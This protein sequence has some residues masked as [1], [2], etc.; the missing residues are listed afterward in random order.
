[1]SKQ[2]CAQSDI[3]WTEY[4]PGRLVHIR[5]H[6]KLRHIDLVN[7]YQHIH[8]PQRLDQRLDFWTHLSSLLSVPNKQN[9]LIMMGDF[10]TSLSRCN[11]AVGIPGY[12]HDENIHAGPRHSDAHLLMNLLTTYDL[13]ATNTWSHALGP[14]YIFGHQTS[15]I[16][17][18][19]CRRA[20]SDNTSKRVH[21]IQDFP[22]ICPT[23][24][25]H[26]P[27]ITSVL[28]VWHSPP[29]TSSTGWSRAQRLDLCQHWQH[30]NERAWHLQ[31]QVQWAMDS[32]PE[33]GDRLAQVHQTL[34]QPTVDKPAS[35]NVAYLSF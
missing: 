29:P 9:T 18:I 16:D 1:M 3:F 6:G 4:V 15:R 20:F 21:Y 30:P 22:L 2:L 27:M 11:A 31:Q 35:K 7:V 32:L 19:I 33:D 23:G 26:V 8:T 24:S 28:R 14:S 12:R 10:N 13:L 25:Y 34:G 17:F 5:I